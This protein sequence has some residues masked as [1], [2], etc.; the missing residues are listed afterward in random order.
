VARSAAIVQAAGYRLVALEHSIGPWGLLGTCSQGLLLVAIVRKTWPSTMGG[1]WGHPA[2]VHC[3][4][5]RPE[6]RAHARRGSVLG[7]LCPVCGRV[8]L[9]RGQT[10]CSAAC[11]RE[12]SRARERRILGERLLLLRAQV[13]DLLAVVSRP[14]QRRRRG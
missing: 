6:G 1:L 4:R 14:V 13:D 2:S 5:S 7:S 8:E 11:R 10:V 9:Q 12:R 3:A